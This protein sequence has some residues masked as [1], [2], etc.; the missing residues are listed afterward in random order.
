VPEEI[1]T[2]DTISTA[3]YYFYDP[4]DQYFADIKHEKPLDHFEV[5]DSEGPYCVD[6]DKPVEWVEEAQ[7]SLD[8][9]EG[10]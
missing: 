7:M 6:C 1:Y 3:Y 8:L 9:G 5:V 4:K 2:D 10:S